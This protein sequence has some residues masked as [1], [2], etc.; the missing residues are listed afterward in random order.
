ML[1]ITPRGINLLSP[2]VMN[3]YSF[4]LASLLK[5]DSD[6][7]SQNIIPSVNQ[8]VFF[9]TLDLDNIIVK[10]KEL[11]AIQVAFKYNEEEFHTVLQKKGNTF[12]PTKIFKSID[13]KLQE[14]NFDYFKNGKDGVYY[15]AE[16]LNKFI[17]A[18]IF[19]DGSTD[20]K[21]LNINKEVV[22]F[23][24]KNMIETQRG[25]NLLL[26][27]D[28]VSEWCKLIEKNIQI[29]NVE[30][31]Q[32]IVK[33]KMS[34][35]FRYLKEEKINEITEKFTSLISN[36][37]FHTI[38][39]DHITK[40][41]LA[42][43]PTMQR[44]NSGQLDEEESIIYLSRNKMITNFLSKSDI[45]IIECSASNYL[46]SGLTNSNI[47]VFYS[48]NIINEK[49]NDFL[50]KENQKKI[51][52]EIK[53][54]LQ[55]IK[56]W[57]VFIQFLKNNDGNNGL[58]SYA[59]LKMLNEQIYKMT[60]DKTLSKLYT[61]IEK[62]VSNMEIDSK[63]LS[64]VNKSKN[65]NISTSERKSLYIDVLQNSLM[66]AKSNI[67]VHLDVTPTE[68]GS[69]LFNSK[70]GQKLPIELFYSQKEAIAN[71]AKNAGLRK[72]GEAIDSYYGMALIG[73][74]EVENLNGKLLPLE[75][76]RFSYKETGFEQISNLISNFMRLDENSQLVYENLD[77]DFNVTKTT[78]PFDLKKKLEDLDKQ[79]KRKFIDDNGNIYKSQLF[80]GTKIVDAYKKIMSSQKDKETLSEKVKSLQSVIKN[81]ETLSKL[82]EI[83]NSK[84]PDYNRIMSFQ[85][86]LLNAPA[87]NK[88]I[89]KHKNDLLEESIY[90]KHPK[91]PKNIKD[92]Y[93]GY[94]LA[95]RA[96]NSILINLEKNLKIFEY[97]DTK[98]NDL[99]ATIEKIKKV[100]NGDSAFDRFQNNEQLNDIK[101]KKI[102]TLDKFVKSVSSL[103]AA[104]YNGTVPPKINHWMSEIIKNEFYPIEER[105]FEDGKEFTNRTTN[106][107]SLQKLIH[108]KT[109]EFG[110]K[111]SEITEKVDKEYQ[112]LKDNAQSNRKTQYS[113]P[114]EFKDISENLENKEEKSTDVESLFIPGLE[115]E[116]IVEVAL[117]SE[118]II[119]QEEEEELIIPENND[120]NNIV[121]IEEDNEKDTTPIEEIFETVALSVKEIPTSDDITLDS[122]NLDS[123]L[124]D[125]NIGD[126]DNI[127]IDGLDEIT[128]DNIGLEEEIEQE[129]F[130]PGGM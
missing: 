119:L 51:E 108:L 44:F 98:D 66:I 36:N 99:N 90:L 100:S 102:F 111:I 12:K 83:G 60:D 93:E 101:Q 84:K 49:Q 103:I 78:Y 34:N 105:I 27:V 110:E 130:A 6:G 21:L 109:K 13:G 94:S 61:A 10:A 128:L 23:V 57:D 125:I 3:K 54:E 126:L 74:T 11:F 30:D 121:I 80:V 55:S 118:K 29:D 68:N 17:T 114:D 91:Y 52:A 14:C 69:R 88:F 63:V 46:L 16:D 67:T 38:D 120:N 62:V 112:S 42:D 95:M 86:S 92:E 39:A 77:N 70:H 115:E 22:D 24:T 56:S 9:D 82:C 97:A 106:L 43:I 64:V 59:Y 81:D 8:N 40:I 4:A 25:Q 7:K 15:N 35:M 53:N 2:E 89:F 37:K 47:P 117:D 45:E 18:L 20:K 32:K 129:P 122:I 50:S 31:F 65:E 28:N 87:I 96:S 113:L 48:S 79:I 123:N 71:F 19:N 41:T 33:L 107:E 26:T 72:N 73:I 75:M 127:V 76:H 116:N 5:K 104:K 1:N 124:G 58:Y 85:T